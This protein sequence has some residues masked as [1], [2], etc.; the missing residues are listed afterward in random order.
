M[1]DNVVEPLVTSEAAQ[2]HA[3]LSNIHLKIKAYVLSIEIKEGK[4]P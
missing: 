3:R 4:Q 2:R 1:T